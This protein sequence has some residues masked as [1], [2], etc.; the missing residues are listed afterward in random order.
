[1]SRTIIKSFALLAF[2]LAC[3]HLAPNAAAQLKSARPPIDVMRRITD[4][5][6]GNKEFKDPVGAVAKSNLEDVNALAQWLSYR[7][8]QPELYGEKPETGSS[9]P[10]TEDTYYKVVDDVQ[11]YIVPTDGPKKLTPSQWEYNKALSDAMFK[12]LTE[13]MK[14]QKMIVKINATRMLSLV[15]K[16]GNEALADE[17]VKMIEDPTSPDYARIYAIQGLAYLL[18]IPN[19]L[20]PG[21]PFFQKEDRLIKTIQT[22]VDVVMPPKIAPKADAPPVPPR[23]PE[24]TR[25]IR[26][27]AV[28]TLGVFPMSVIRDVNGKAAVNIGYPLLLVAIRDK[29]ITP[30]PTASEQVEALIGFCTKIPDE[31]LSLEYAAVG[32]NVAII[33]LVRYKN[34]QSREIPWKLSAARLTL[35]LNQW[36]AATGKLKASRDPKKVADLVD[37][38][39]ADVLKNLEASGLTGTTTVEKLSQMLG[40]QVKSLYAD[41]PKTILYGPD[42]TAEN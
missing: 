25:F 31:E 35:A 19:Q 42:A 24:I 14:N 8:T 1:M 16:A 13:V 30:M 33:D 20:Q 29:Q 36:K 6:N 10:V 4:M 23:P 18:A 26:R 11:K 9:L 32:V 12:H 2:G 17:F 15:G 39:I 40:T 27:E 22:L 41:D 34:N 3:C 38:A 5:Q 37:V 21:K 28:K 7:L